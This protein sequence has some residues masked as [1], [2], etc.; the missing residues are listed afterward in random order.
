MSLSMDTAQNVELKNKNWF[1]TGGKARYFCKPE[2]NTDFKEALNFAKE[3]DLKVF[4]LGSGANVLISDNGF[5]GLVIKP[6]L[7]Q[8]EIVS[9][10]QGFIKSGAGVQIL[11]L[12][13][14]CLDSNFVGLEEFSGIPGT[15]G[16]SVYINIHY[17]DSLLSDFIVSATI[18]DRKSLLTKKVD[19]DWF[20]F[21]YDTSKLENK[22]HFL[23]DATFKLKKVDDD[24]VSYAKGRRDEI[25][26]HRNIRYP[27]AGTCGSFFRNFREDDDCWEKLPVINERKMKFAAYYL[28]K[29]GVKG[30]LSHGGA[31]VSSKHANM[32]VNE[33]NASTQDI[34]RVAKEMQSLVQEKYGF[35]LEPECQLVGFKEYPLL[36]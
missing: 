12:I 28:D 9:E 4:I 30:S 17:F 33:S 6:N 36:K 22:E 21:G 10:E 1:K 11:E 32:I 16:G 19:K 25:I 13:N 27:T 18:I 24:E 5:Q 8:K 35:I 26:R 3:K 29:I 20:N 15:V 14:Y 31:R 2:S 34:I 23:L 7:K